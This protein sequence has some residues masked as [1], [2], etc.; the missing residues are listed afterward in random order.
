MNKSTYTSAE[1]EVLSGLEPVQKRP[2]MF[3]DVSNPLH[4][5][6]EVIDNS[7]DEAIAKHAKKIIVTLHNDFSITVEDDGR[8]MPVDIHKEHGISGVELIMTRLH[9]GGKFSNKNYRF[10]GGLHGVGI[11]VVNALSSQ[12]EVWVKRQGKCHYMKFINGEKNAKLK[13]IAKVA[14]RNT[15]TKVKFIPNAKYFDTCKISTTKLA[16]ILR[17]KA[18]LCA[19]LYVVFHD[20]VHDEKH[21]WHFTDGIADYLTANLENIEIIP[22]PVFA[23]NMIATNEEV[24]W[25]LCW[26]MDNCEGIRESYVNLIPTAQGGT[27]VNGLR[28]GLL[29]AVRDYCDFRKLLP[30]GLK[31]SADDIW[32]NCYYLLSL[33]ILE[34]QFF[35]QTKE[36][37][38]SRKCTSFVSGVIK[39]TFLLWLNQN[40]AIADNLIAM[41]IAR[42]EARLRSSAKVKRKRLLS[43][44]ALPG[45]LAD[46][47]S[48]NAA[49]GELFIVEGD[50]AGGSAKQARDKEFQA[51][52]P[53]RGK[54]LNTWELNANKIL[55]SKEVHD[56]AVAI[57]VD[58]GSDDL[59]K[60]RYHKICILADADSDGAHIATLIC[61]LFV[62]HFADVVKAGY[63]YLALPPLYR[64]Q[65][66]KDIYY[67]LDEEDKQGILDR[68]VAENTKSTPKILRFKGLGEMN[69]LQLR[70]TTMD[71]ATRR[72]VQLTMN[73]IP[74]TL[75]MLDLL[76]AKKRSLDRKDWLENKGNIAEI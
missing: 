26:S 19:N 47:S 39:D 72:L 36:K 37:L 41:F 55:E 32:D 46:C 30:K 73:D 44:P 69:P 9:A 63:F 43:G 40:V 66:N 57:G 18:V 27:H 38:S 31:L 53:L 59:S 60:L 75:S 76:L 16:N 61:G 35:G 33:K 11:S 17:A 5:T 64:I 54:I 56:I 48:Q 13:V 70:E 7:V 23:G 3:T 22:N 71:P 49:I 4:I 34:P 20:E 28:I 29:E 67:A 74:Q 1:I 65:V 21:E 51:I 2:N 45:K 10:S 24:S 58:P 6:Q 42:A 14:A 15:G 25:A 68:L 12:L 50:S 62:K 8:G 52:M